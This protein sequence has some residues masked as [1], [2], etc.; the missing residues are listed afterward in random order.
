MNSFDV[1]MERAYTP[2]VEKKMNDAYLK[3]KASATSANIQSAKKFFEEAAKLEKAGNKTEAKA[4]Y[5]K[6]LKMMKIVKAKFEGFRSDLMTSGSRLN[7]LS[8]VG[9]GIIIALAGSFVSLFIAC[10]SVFL[11]FYGISFMPMKIG[12]MVFGGLLYEGGPIASI[13]GGIS[14]G[15]AQDKT[16]YANFKE[17]SKSVKENPAKVMNNI[18]EMLDESIDEI[19]NKI[20]SL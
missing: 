10:W 7:K 2:E 6:S 9:I 5:K 4:M 16:D 19:Q 12:A 1:V 14:Y 17:F 18:S 13:A 3:A 20:R 15:A 8:D 11:G